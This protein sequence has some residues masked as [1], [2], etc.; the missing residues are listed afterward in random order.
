MKVV[1]MMNF[2]RQIDER[3]QNSTAQM[4]EFT[5][6]LI[7]CKLGANVRVYKGSAPFSQ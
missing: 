1:N 4:F 5:R 7:P 2:V 3:K 6:E